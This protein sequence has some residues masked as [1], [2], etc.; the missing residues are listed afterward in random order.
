MQ[1]RCGQERKHARSAA[2]VIFTKTRQLCAAV[3][4]K[5]N[6]DQL[7]LR[8]LARRIIKFTAFSR[9]PCVY[10]VGRSI[11]VGKNTNDNGT[12]GLGEPPGN[13]NERGRLRSRCEVCK[14]K[15]LEIGDADLSRCA[16]SRN[17]LQKVG[18]ALSVRHY[19]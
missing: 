7:V 3:T 9:Y 12:E 18:L 19:Q 5:T 1:E 6:T 13:H 17:L 11:S 8:A 15:R 10:Y 2:S 4:L 16:L 14:K